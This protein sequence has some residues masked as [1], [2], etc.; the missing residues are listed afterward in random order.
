M[1]KTYMLKSIDIQEYYLVGDV[2][3]LG[4]TL[5]NQGL[6]LALSAKTY[7]Q[8][9]IPKCE[10]LFG[11]EFINVRE[12]CYPEVDSSLLYTEDDFTLC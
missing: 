2:E 3:F 7:I 10:G 12:G 9:V 11:K 4:E 8:S 6:E 1:K 5:N